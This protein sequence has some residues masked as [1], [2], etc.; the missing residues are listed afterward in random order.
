MGQFH[1]RDTTTYWNKSWKRVKISCPKLGN[2]VIVCAN[3]TIVGNVNIGNNAFIGAGAVVIHDVPNNS[4]VVGNPAKVVS[5]KGKE[6]G[7]TY[8]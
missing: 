3:A 2:D 1:Y 6:I 5:N 8:L 4:V 7:N